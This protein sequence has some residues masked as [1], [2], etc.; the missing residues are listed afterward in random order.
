LRPRRLKDFLRKAAAL[1]LVLTGVTI[2]MWGLGAT[3]DQV[4]PGRLW[5]IIM[6]AAMPVAILAALKITPDG[7]TTGYFDQNI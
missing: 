7:G 2:G 3:I 1:F 6:M 5:G 4:P